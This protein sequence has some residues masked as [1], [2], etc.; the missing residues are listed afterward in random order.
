ITFP[1]NPPALGQPSFHTDHWDPVFAAAQDAAMP[2]CMHFGTGGAPPIQPG[3]PFAVA[4]ALMGMNSQSTA[5][6][7][8]FS[9]MFRKFPGLRVALS[10]GGIGWMPYVLEPCDYTWERHRYYQHL[11]LAIPPSEVFR[12]HIFGCFIS[13][14]VGL[15]LLD[16]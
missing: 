7:M 11:E 10:E 12:D 16:R 2:L 4:I 3:A 6:E 5:V 14:E 8:L 15:T 1:E 13:D 9:P